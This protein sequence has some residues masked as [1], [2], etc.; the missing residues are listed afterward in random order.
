MQAF[1]RPHTPTLPDSSRSYPYLTNCIIAKNG[2]TVNIY[3]NF[4]V[5]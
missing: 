4:L 2:K 1:S 5:Y 3:H